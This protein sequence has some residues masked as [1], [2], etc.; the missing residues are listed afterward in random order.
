[1]ADKAPA[2]KF[3][4]NVPV[5]CE[6]RF[7]DIRPGKLW[8]DPENGKAKML[9]SQVSIK[10]KFGS[11]DTICFLPGPAWKNIKSLAESGILTNVEQAMADANNEGLDKVT[12]VAFSNGKVTLTIAKPAGERYESLVVDTGAVKPAQAGRVESP[13]APPVKPATKPAAKPLPFDLPS[14]DERFA[15]FDA[16]L[17]G[18]E[19][20]SAFEPE[21]PAAPIASQKEAAYNALWERV[22]KFQSAMAAEYQFPFDAAS[23]NA[24]TFSIAK[25]A[26]IV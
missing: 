1:M 6:I 4:V 9:P 8:T 14:E 18:V 25:A 26:G 22:A 21:Q 15:A 13:Y 23:I 11:L 3:T 5:P 19:T 7:I 12:A 20:E 10:G 17:S 24:H 2:F 16:A